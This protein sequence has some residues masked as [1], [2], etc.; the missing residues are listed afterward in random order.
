V[1]ASGLCNKL[2]ML[3]VLMNGIACDLEKAI[4][5]HRGDEEIENIKL[6]W[7]EKLLKRASN[8]NVKDKER[9]CEQIFE[10]NRGY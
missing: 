8:M 5:Q 10:A 1:T 9:P 2:T 4:Q 7:K 3:E 6:Q